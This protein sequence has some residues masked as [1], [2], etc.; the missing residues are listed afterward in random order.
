MQKCYITVFVPSE[1]ILKIKTKLP[2][3]KDYKKHFPE[4]QIFIYI[5]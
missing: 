3:A 1:Q 2:A 4:R 5:R